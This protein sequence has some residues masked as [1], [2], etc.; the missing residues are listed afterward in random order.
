MIDKKRAGREILRLQSMLGYPTTGPAVEDLVEELMKS[1]NEEQA[2]GVISSFKETATT[3]TRCP[4]SSDIRRALWD[5]QES[6]RKAIAKCV[7]CDGTG[8]VI[9]PMLVTYRGAG[10][11]IAE[12]EP[13]RGSTE[14]DIAAFT[15][16]IIH[17]KAAGVVGPDQTILTFAEP[18]VCR[19][20]GRPIVRPDDACKRCQGCGIYG[21]HMGG[22]FA[23]E[24]KWCDCEAAENRKTLEP[25]LINEANYWR[26]KNM[27]IG[28]NGKLLS[29]QRKAVREILSVIDGV[30]GQ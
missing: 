5:A 26:D 11:L 14:A 12:R 24:W 9:I 29:G 3:E 23:G 20:L 13:L 17:A 6:R 8:S 15:A 27:Q 1:Q 19:K 22:K 4:T 2:A 30:A 10:F 7:A 28:Q 25:E 16:Q 18:C 21:G